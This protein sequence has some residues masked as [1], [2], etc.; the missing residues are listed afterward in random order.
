MSLQP[1]FLAPT[2]S[3]GSLNDTDPSGLP[4]LCSDDTCP[5]PTNPHLPAVL[6]LVSAH[7]VKSYPFFKVHLEHHPLSL[8]LHRASPSAWFLELP[9]LHRALLNTF[10]DSAGNSTCFRAS[11]I[12]IC[13]FSIA[14][15][16]RIYKP[17]ARDSWLRSRLVPGRSPFMSSKKM[18]HQT[19]V[20]GRPE[21][22]LDTY[23]L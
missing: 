1:V 5:H 14:D 21:T 7:A 10:S 23:K 9:H 6:F 13:F 17:S 3:I 20:P 16:L 4:R 11:Q 18:V 8:P 15:T 12:N 2:T 22:F 19:I